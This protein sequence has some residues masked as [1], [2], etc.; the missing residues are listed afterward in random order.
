LISAIQAA[1]G[2]LR[3]KIG[4]GAHPYASAAARID[5]WASSAVI[6]VV[7]A[8]AI[9]AFSDWEEWLNLVLG[10]WLASA[11]WILGYAHTRAAHVRVA[12]GAIVAYLAAALKKSL[13]I[14]PAFTLSGC[15]SFNTFKAASPTLFECKS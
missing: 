10:I 3:L 13:A 4:S 5:F 14:K 2:I 8:A 15:S 9:A 1:T 6:A 12:A 11:P 7:S